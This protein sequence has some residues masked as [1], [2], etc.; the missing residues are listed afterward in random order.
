MSKENLDK[1]YMKIYRSMFDHK[2]WTE[3]RQFSRHEAWLFLIK[4]A[5]YKEG[6]SER[7]INNKPI[8]WGRG[9][10]VASVRYLKNAW[11]WK[12]NKKVET[13]LKLLKKESMVVTNIRRG[14]TV[15]TICKYETYNSE[16]TARRQQGDGEETARRQNSKKGKESKEGEVEQN[17]SFSENLNNENLPTAAPDISLAGIKYKF[18]IEWEK[19]FPEYVWGDSDNFAYEKLYSFFRK[20]LQKKNDNE[21][22]I[23]GSKVTDGKILEALV[24]YA[25]NLP[26]WIID[27]GYLSMSYISKDP[28]KI[29]SEI[30]ASKNKVVTMEKPPFGWEHDGDFI[31]IEL[32]NGGYG[33]KRNKDGSIYRKSEQLAKQA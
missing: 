24:Y 19:L 27:K 13:F 25:A 29:I 18:K 3:K 26:T 9:E 30:K 22:E 31:K 10:L 1:G 16:E 32:L 8:K 17:S 4:E 2:F 33:P 12:S 23:K 28:N 5:R 21:L 11:G 14:V 20:R 6:Q 7:M 15:I